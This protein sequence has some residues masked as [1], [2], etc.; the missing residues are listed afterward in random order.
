MTSGDL[1]SEYTEEFGY[2]LLFSNKPQSLHHKEILPTNTDQRGI[3][4]LT[5]SI[6]RIVNMSLIQALC[7]CLSKKFSLRALIKGLLFTLH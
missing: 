2:K 4:I 3:F 5:K 7:L 6:H 1:P